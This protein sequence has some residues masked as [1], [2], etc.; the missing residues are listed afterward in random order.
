M[1]TAT[2]PVPLSDA[3]RQLF[4]EVVPTD[5]FRRRLPQVV[6]F[7][8]FRAS[9]ESAYC[10]S[11]RPPIDCI[12]VLKL[13]LLARPFRWSDRCCRAMATKEPMPSS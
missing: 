12:L 9:L 3:E 7:E 11:G 10:G 5:H 6:D 2:N 8:E 4:D 1:L 13:E